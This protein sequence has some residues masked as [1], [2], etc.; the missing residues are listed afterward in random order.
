M[1]DGVP[2]AIKDEIDCLPYP[3]TGSVKCYFFSSKV[4]YIKM[5]L[6]CRFHNSLKHLKMVSTRRYKVA[7]QRKDLQR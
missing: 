4:L 1:L 7:A 2:V 6:S 3:T 5:I